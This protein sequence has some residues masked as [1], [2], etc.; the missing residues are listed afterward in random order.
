MGIRCRD[1]KM[2][3]ENA[4]SVIAALK[5]L[6]HKLHYKLYMLYASD[7]Y[8]T[9]DDI[10]D[11]VGITRQ[12][13]ASYIR[14][15]KPCSPSI[16]TLCRLC[17]YFKVPLWYLLNDEIEY[18]VYPDELDTPDGADNMAMGAVMTHA[19]KSTKAPERKRQQELLRSC[20]LDKGVLLFL[21]PGAREALTEAI[22][23]CVDTISSNDDNWKKPIYNNKGEVSYSTD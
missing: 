11:A 17:K 14:P 21:T 5:K 18:C 2:D 4:D 22:K 6:P 10:A 12:A 23:Q 19:L 16:P 13:F 7:S 8:K 20:G 3:S 15:N 1:S 9:Q